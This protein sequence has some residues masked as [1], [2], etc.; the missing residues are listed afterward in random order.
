MIQYRKLNSDEMNRQLFAD[1]QRKQVVTKCRRKVN[2]EWVVKDI[3][4]IDDWS[5]QDYNFL[6]KCLRNTLT[7]GGLVAGAFDG[8][9]LKGFVSVEAAMFGSDAQYMDL[10]SLHVSADMRRNGMGKQLFWLAKEYAKQC[11]A[12][13]LYISSHSA[14]ETQAFYRAMGCVEAKEYHA[15][16]VEREPCDCQLEYV[17]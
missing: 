9:R 15:G 12:K 5:E 6:V 11:G 4:F 16:H 14:V 8:E 7:S 17:L 3:A 2:H 13:K 10:S 1:F